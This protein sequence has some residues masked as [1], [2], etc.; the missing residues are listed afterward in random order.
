MGVVIHRCQVYILVYIYIHYAMRFELWSC[1]YMVEQHTLLNA[2]TNHLMSWWIWNSTIQEQGVT[3]CFFQWSSN[4]ASRAC[5]LPWACHWMFGMPRNLKLGGHGFYESVFFQ[6]YI[7]FGH[8]NEDSYGKLRFIVWN[9][10]LF[11]FHI[12][13]TSNYS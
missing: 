2:I 5:S 8:S 3:I 9:I 12:I 10:L 7:I 13:V 6:R 11:N 1:W 4:I